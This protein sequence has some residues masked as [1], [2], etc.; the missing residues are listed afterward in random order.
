MNARESRRAVFVVDG[1]SDIEMSYV[2]RGTR[3][4]AFS[5]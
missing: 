5:P 3:V 2:L 1:T 4:E